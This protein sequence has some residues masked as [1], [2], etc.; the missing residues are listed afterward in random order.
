[1]GFR[2]RAGGGKR[3]DA[4]KAIVGA[5]EAAGARVWRLGG[6]GNPDLLVWARGTFM[7]LEVKTARRR[8]TA[9]QLDIPWPTVRTATDALIVCGFG[10]R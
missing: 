9:N 4:E 7:P 10:A 1:M 2:R 3:D 5:L 8:W 6:T